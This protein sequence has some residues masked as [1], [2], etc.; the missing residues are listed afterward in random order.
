VDSEPLEHLPRPL[1]VACLGL[2]LLPQPLEHQLLAVFSALPLPLQV[3]VCLVH[4]PHLLAVACLVLLRQHTEC[5]HQRRRITVLQQIR[6]PNIC[7]RRL[8]LDP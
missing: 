7:Q 1:A 6:N 5:R 2:Q 3:V 4:H 8:P